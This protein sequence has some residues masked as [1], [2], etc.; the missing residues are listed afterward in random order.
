M[1]NDKPVVLVLGASLDQLFL[2]ETAQAMGCFVVAV[3]MDPQAPA[4][5]Y[6]DD[7]AVVST[8]DIEGLI[9]FARTYH[10]KRPINAVVT[11]GSDIPLSVAAVCEELKLPS[12]SR[13][14]A[15]LASNK[16]LMKQHWK[17]K[18]I[19]IPWFEE[20][21]SGE[22]LARV[23]RERGWELIVKPTDRSGA[24]G[25]T[26]LSEGMDTDLVFQKAKDLS[27]E[28][29]V[30]V[31]EFI[32]GEQESTESI[33]YKDFF[34]TAGVSDRNYDQMD[35]LKGAPIENGGTMPSVLP[36]DK[37]EAM[38]HLLE[39]AARAL[40]ITS[41]VAKGDVVFN[42]YGQPVMIEMAARLSG[43]WMSSGLIPI[44]S[45]V[46]IAETV[47]EIA[48]GIEPDLTKLEPKFQ[49]HS[50]LRYFFPPP[51]RIVRFDGIEK[52]SRI[53][54][55]RGLEFYKNIGDIIGDPSSH[56]DRAGGFILE[57]SSRQDVLEKA[58]HIYNI[59]RIVTK[60]T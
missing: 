22:H 56:A 59:V 39:D 4:F 14:T 26:K 44:T 58:E 42:K 33:V 5:K 13:K 9:S 12:I 16:L 30:I 2:I 28:G 60:P 34:I 43:G 38:D 6:A 24:R 35:K 31:E 55:L 20:L 1:I 57:G 51:G 50:A 15:L 40:G 19:P 47:V 37:L 52:T 53:K 54:W 7:R 49:K 48:L 25:I 29:R 11:M 21:E 46:N 23:I 27:F 45:G 3:D 32:S 36:R 18:G 41:G 10:K 8:R 17:E